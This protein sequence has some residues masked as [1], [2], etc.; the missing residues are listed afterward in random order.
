MALGAALVAG[1]TSVVEVSLV[2]LYAD[3]SLMHEPLEVRKLLAIS[4][5]Y[6]GNDLAI[7]AHA[8][9][10]AITLEFDGTRF[11]I[12]DTSGL[13]RHIYNFRLLRE[14]HGEQYQRQP[15]YIFH[16]RP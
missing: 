5:G 3:V 9:G 10:D 11:I 7:T 14:Y 6:D 4:A 12:S 2:V 13:L 8:E 16:I 15:E 1:V